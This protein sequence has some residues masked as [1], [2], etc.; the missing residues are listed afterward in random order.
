MHRWVMEQMEGRPL[1]SSEAVMHRCDNRL[2]YRV[3]HLQIGSVALNNLD[4]FIKGRASP[5]PVNRLGGATNP[6]ARLD[7][8][9]VAEIRAMLAEGFTQ[10]LI[11]RQFGVSTSQIQRIA[12]GRAW[13]DDD[14]QP[15]DPDVAGCD[16]GP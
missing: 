15:P 4:M 9:A 8:E 16:P 6:N 2:C 14:E 11:A 13:K 7:V 5:P 12:A 3:D 1:K 10:A